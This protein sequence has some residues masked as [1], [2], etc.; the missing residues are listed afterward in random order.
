MFLLYELSSPFLNI[1]WFCDKLDLTGSIYQAINGAFLT[2]TFF[3]CRI[4]W[5]NI[6]SIYVFYDIY[7]GVKYGNTHLFPISGGAVKTDSPLVRTY[8]T[9]ELL[10]IYHDEQGQRYAFA[11]ER[12]VPLALGLVYLASNIT[13]NSLNIFWFGK[14]VQTIR[15]RFDPPLGTKGV[16]AKEIHYEPIEKIAKVEKQSLGDA[17]EAIE[18]AKR[19]GR[20]AA[21]ASP[22]K[23]AA[24]APVPVEKKQGS[25]AAA[26]E[27]AEAALDKP[28]VID[29]A[30]QVQRATFS[31][32]TSGVEVEGK[33]TLRTRRKA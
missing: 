2:G 8:T 25:V 27:R 15:S 28:I 3:A 32:G 20:A 33:R 17:R 12:N 7:H 1:H 13:L 29:D 14:M 11:G 19:E 22:M 10:N 6:S 31:D 9:P 16:G 5:G 26:R 21:A 18:R 23:V 24:P 4:I 30:A